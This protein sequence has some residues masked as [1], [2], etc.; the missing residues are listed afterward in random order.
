MA[1]PVKSNSTAKRRPR[2]RGNDG[3]YT[4]RQTRSTNDGTSRCGSKRTTPTQQ[5]QRR[6]QNSE[7]RQRLT[8]SETMGGSTTTER[9]AGMM[10]GTRRTSR[11][12]ATTKTRKR[13]QDSHE[14]RPGQQQ[15]TMGVGSTTESRRKTNEPA[16]YG[17]RRRMTETE[18]RRSRE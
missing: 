4:D 13:H 11:N 18:R 6:R 2:T 15:C 5:Q 12:T 8:V 1:R 16:R 7:A 17:V 14:D 10:A 9:L 3:D